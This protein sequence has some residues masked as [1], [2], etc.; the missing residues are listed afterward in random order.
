MREV[1][2]DQQLRFP[3]LCISTQRPDIFIYS[4]K[5]RKVILIELTCPAEENIE[6][7]HSEKISRYEGLLKDCIN[8]GW[9][10]HL[11]AIEVG[12]CGYASCLLRSCLSRL[13]FIQRTV[14]DI[15]KKASHTALGCSFW[16]WLKRM[17]RY[18]SNTERRKESLVK[19]I[20]SDNPCNQQSRVHR[21]SQNNSLEIQKKQSKTETRKNTSVKKSNQVSETQTQSTL[22]MNRKNPSIRKYAANQES[23]MSTQEKQASYP[24]INVVKHTVTTK[25]PWGLRNA[26][27]TCYM[28]AIFQCLAEGA[29]SLRSSPKQLVRKREI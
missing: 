26:G 28:N 14:R 6:E 7:R 16:I 29:S 17:D 3:G 23:E 22:N 9:K 27:N 12:A 15:I 4:L 19:G 11:F 25:G 2:L 10:V 5:L 1:D 18:W 13:G 8:A 21:K 24:E 20:N